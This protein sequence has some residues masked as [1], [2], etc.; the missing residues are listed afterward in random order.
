M[1]ESW[2]PSLH[3]RETAGRCRLSVGGG[4][5]GEGRTLQEA[6][7]DLVGRLLKVALGLRRN[8]ITVS[9]E[10][11]PDLH[12]LEFLWELGEIAERGGDVR[13]RI[14]GPPDP[15]GQSSGVTGE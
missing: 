3:L 4:P 10:M 14:F 9:V 8:G 13:E 15:P 6:A 12:W 5:C 1:A 11:P 2:A 7:D